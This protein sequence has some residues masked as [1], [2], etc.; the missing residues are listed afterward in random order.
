MPDRYETSVHG[1]APDVTLAYAMYGDPVDD[2]GRPD[3][4]GD[5][6]V[7]QVWSVFQDY[8]GCL[9]EGC[10]AHPTKTGHCVGHSRSLG[11]VENW[12]QKGRQPHE[13]D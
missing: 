1:S 4:T 8:R 12:N 2:T 3:S 5:D 6:V 11:L 13:S 9:T 7:Q 10:R